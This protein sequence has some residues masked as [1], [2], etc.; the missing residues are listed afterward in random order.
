[1]SLSDEDRFVR[2]FREYGHALRGHLVAMVRD[3][4]LADDLLQD[5]FC[6]AWQSRH[7]N[8]DVRRERAYPAAEVPTK[9]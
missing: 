5:V 6:R 7:R 9:T 1:M 3:R 4:E 8:R 2:W